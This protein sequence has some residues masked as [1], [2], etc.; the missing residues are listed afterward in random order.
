[1][2]YRCANVHARLEDTVNN[3]ANVIIYDELVAAKDNGHATLVIDAKM[4]ILPQVS[5]KM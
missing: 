2:I 5:P 3:V 4:E 1:M